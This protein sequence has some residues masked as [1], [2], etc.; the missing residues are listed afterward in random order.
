M[1]QAARINDPVSH[2]G[3]PLTPGP[4]NG[5][6]GV[7]AGAA[8]PGLPAN[9]GSPLLGVPS[10]RIAGQ[11]A[12]VVGSLCV[13]QLHLYLAQG[14]LVLPATPPPT[15]G[16]VLIGGFPAARRGD[17]VTCQATISTGAPNVIIGG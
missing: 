11:P 4:P 5:T 14:N 10:V 12:A 15:S 8:V 3:T 2:L 1:P 16:K 17:R 6:L 7:P 13:C 9:A